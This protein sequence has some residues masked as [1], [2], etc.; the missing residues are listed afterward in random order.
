MCTMSTG[1]VQ[2]Y[3]CSTEVYK[4]TVVIQGYSCTRIFQLCR[5]TVVEQA[6]NWYSDSVPGVVQGYRDTGV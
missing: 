3:R 5:G 2:G 6:H 1:E 4:G